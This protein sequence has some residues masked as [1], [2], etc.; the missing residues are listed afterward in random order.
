MLS[1]GYT[2]IEQ[3]GIAKSY[4]DDLLSNYIRLFHCGI[5]SVRSAESVC[6]AKHLGTKQIASNTVQC[7]FSIN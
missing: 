5:V 1:G 2:T 6:F 7:R 4:G 3:N